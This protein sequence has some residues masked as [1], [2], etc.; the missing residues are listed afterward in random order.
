L[1]NSKFN[2][3]KFAREVKQEA[4]RVSWPSR[5]ETL[6]STAIVLTIT[7]IA[8]LFFVMVDGLAAWVI[9]LILGFGG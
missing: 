4:S 2:P 3:A 8:S 7:V 5:R 9:R 1:S 6:T